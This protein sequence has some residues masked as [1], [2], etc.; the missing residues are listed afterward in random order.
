M[1]LLNLGAG[2]RISEEAGAVNHDVTKHREEINAVWDLNKTPWSLW[3]TDGFDEIEFISTIEHL[4]I[5]PIQ[6]LNE[7]HRILKKRGVLTI[8]YPLV[9]SETIWDDPT[10]TRFLTERSLDYVIPGTRYGD[11]YSFYTNLKWERLDGGVIKAR[12]YKARMTPIKP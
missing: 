10:H 12:N 11:S 5:N 8:K 3:E 1:K 7:C 2:N 6:A 9:T 4:L